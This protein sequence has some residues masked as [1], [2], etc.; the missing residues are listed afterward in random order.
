MSYIRLV[1]PPQGW[2]WS[3]PT[4][5]FPP[6][7]PQSA[8]FSREAPDDGFL[9]CAP[10]LRTKQRASVSACWHVHLLMK[11]HIPFQQ[12]GSTSVCTV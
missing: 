5:S 2:K 1:A 12:A 8:L 6:I 10:A 7:E 11:R 4:K 9:S 3:P